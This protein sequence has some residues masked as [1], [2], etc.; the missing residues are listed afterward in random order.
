MRNLR[1]PN[2][3]KQIGKPKARVS[4]MLFNGDS[5]IL[6]ENLNGAIVITTDEELLVRQIRISLWCIESKKRTQF[7]YNNGNIKEK[8]RWEQSPIYHTQGILRHNRD[9]F[10][11]YPFTARRF[12][13]SVN[14][15]AGA[16]ESFYRADEK[17]WW[18]LEAH[19]DVK[20]RR[21]LIHRTAF[22]VVRPASGLNE[23]TILH[24]REVVLIPCRYC[25]S[26]NPNTA[27]HCSRCGAGLES[28]YPFNQLWRE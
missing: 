26:L 15:P 9:Q 11:F 13:F 17:V 14:I 6:G 24:Q 8:Q 5:V 10:H 7:E 25:R 2:F 28:S 20:G 22:Q 21:D 23:R 27:T 12:R 1:I 4:F 19:I 3:L 16:K 18:T